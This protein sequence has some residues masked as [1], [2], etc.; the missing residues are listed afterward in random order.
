MK[1]KKN[2][3]SEKSVKITVRKE[4]YTKNREILKAATEVSCSGCTE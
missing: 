3:K 2:E 4:S 1:S